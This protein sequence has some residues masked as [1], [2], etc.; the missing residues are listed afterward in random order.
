MTKVS[1]DCIDIFK[2]MRILHIRPAETPPV[3]WVGMVECLSKSGDVIKTN[4]A[5]KEYP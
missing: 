1:V 3:S 4:L 5:V 2:G